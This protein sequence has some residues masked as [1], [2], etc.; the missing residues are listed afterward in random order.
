MRLTIQHW[1]VRSTDDLDS[2]VEE[3]LLALAPRLRIEEAIVAFDYRYEESPAFNVRIH[4]VTPGP[5]LRV[6]AAD[7]TIFAAFDRALTDLNRKLDRR[8]RNRAGRTRS[9]QQKPAYRRIGA[10]HRS[11]RGKSVRLS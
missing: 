9:N 7:H 2:R 3:R 10:S 4:L 8:D 6:E 11:T 1:H 5:D